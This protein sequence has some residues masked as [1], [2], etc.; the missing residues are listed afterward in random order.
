MIKI[1]KISFFIAFALSVS[2]CAR[3]S[4]TPS[5]PTIKGVFVLCEGDFGTPGDYSF[6]NTDKDSVANN[7]FSNSNGGANLGLIPDFIYLYAPVIYIT[8][9]GGYGGTGKMFKIDYNTNQL[10][11]T[12]QSFG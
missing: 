1:V 7:I 3:D 5:N 10:L 12:S 6:I 9:Q 4:F 8:S 2:G 11:E